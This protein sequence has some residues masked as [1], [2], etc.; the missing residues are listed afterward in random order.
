M[1]EEVNQAR[2]EINDPFDNK[3]IFW[4]LRSK[5]HWLKE[6]HRNTKFFHAR[7]FE[8]KKQNTILG[9]YDKDGNWCGDQ[10]SI[11]KAA[12]SCFEEIYS[13]SFLSQIENVI[14][15]IPAKVTNGMN[16]ELSKAFTREEVVSALKQLHSTKSPGSDGM[17][18]LF[19]QKYWSIVGINVSNMVLNVLN[20]GMTL[21]EINRTNIALM[22]K[23]N[24]P[25][26]MTDFRP[27]SL[28]NVVYKLISKTISKRLKAIL[29]HIITKNQSAFTADRLITDKVLVAYEIMHF[30]K[31]KRGWN[32]SFMAAKLDMSKAFDRVEWIFIEKVMRKMGFNEGWINLVMK[33]I[34]SVS[35]LVIINDM[36]HGNIVP[37]RGLRQGDSLSLYL[38]LLCAEGFSALIHDAT[39]TKQLNGT[40]IYRG[41]PK[42][43]HL[44]FANGSLLFCRANGDECNKL[45]EIL[46]IYEFASGPKI[47]TDKSFIFFS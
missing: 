10:D 2:K 5:A 3:E 7:V 34:S 40:S 19:F 30:L 21:F 41:A 38:F 42:I 45:K 46:G 8:R 25:Q 36:T 14:D 32:D 17:L 43:I 26:R 15:P 24:N 12:I 23:T 31:K 11:A 28:S 27:I 13:T 47:N 39:R 1:G 44:F 20:F 22:P 9:I 37:T 29:P 18:A 35:Y 16:S 4:G 6:G 33:C